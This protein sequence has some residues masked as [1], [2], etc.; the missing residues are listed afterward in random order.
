MPS[1]RHKSRTLRKVFVKTPGGKTKIHYKKKKPAKAICAS[2]RKPLAGVARERPKKMKNMAKTKK[3]PERAFG[4]VLCSACS[5]K[6]LKKKARS[7]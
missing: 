1:G 2:C 3:R 4:G 6:E 7:I 5:R